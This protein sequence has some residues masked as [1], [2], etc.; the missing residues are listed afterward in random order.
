MT[1]DAVLSPLPSTGYRRE[2]PPGVTAMVRRIRESFAAVEPHADEAAKLFYGMLFSLAPETRDLFPANMEVQRSRLM[3]AL[4]HVVQ[5]VDKPDDLIPFLRQLGRDHRKFGVIAGH[6]EAVGTALLAT[7]KKF[8]G[9]AW[10][11]QV[12]RAWA[13]AYTIMARSM[14]EAAAADEGP[15][16]WN[17]T[18]LEHKRLTW[19]L[20]IVR[21]QPDYPVPY[22]P[23]QY[24]SV[25][26]PQR[27]RLWRYL[28]PANAPRA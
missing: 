22:R 9:D 13:E 3:R 1:A 16:Y 17:A 10:D 14:Q 20:A 2:P 7:I 15:A 8:A 18:V 5:A 19:D 23:G 6:Y 26:I 25:E 4:V 11:A 28:S 24:V 12:E 21:V 27:E